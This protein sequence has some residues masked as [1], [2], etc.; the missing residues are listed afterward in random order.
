MERFT[1]QHE[2][3]HHSGFEEA[4]RMDRPV[5]GKDT[6]V[7]GRGRPTFPHRCARGLGLGGTRQSFLRTNH[8]LFFPGKGTYTVY[9]GVSLGTL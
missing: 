5:T 9:T 7:T 8:F 6:P 2:T 4:D 1:E 3:Q